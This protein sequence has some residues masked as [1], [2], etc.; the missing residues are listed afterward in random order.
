MLNKVNSLLKC[1]L[2]VKGFRQLIL[3]SGLIYNKSRSSAF[4]TCSIIYNNTVYFNKENVVNANS[5]NPSNVLDTNE[6][7]K[8][9]EL[10]IKKV[11]LEI[12]AVEKKVEE[13][14]DKERGYW[15]D[16]KRQLRDEKNKLNERLNLLLTKEEK[17]TK[18]ICSQ[19]CF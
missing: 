16:E 7:I 1:N 17:C 10:E 14:D 3:P 5:E 8:K 19:L 2:M 9:V 13:T 6:Q 18:V 15:M 12:N 11:E 4:S